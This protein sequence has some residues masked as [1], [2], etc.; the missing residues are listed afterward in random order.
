MRYIMTP[1]EILDGLLNSDAMDDLVAYRLR[2]SL[3]TSI[4]TLERLY[5]VK[6]LTPYQF[7]DYVET[8]RYARALTVVLEW[9]TTDDMV[10]VTIELNKFS[11]RLDNEF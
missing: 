4:E 11:M 1:H 10:E 2:L 8:L 5:D 3:E 6:V 7:E 9:F